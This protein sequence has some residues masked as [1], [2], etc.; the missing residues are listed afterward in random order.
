M[1]IGSFSLTWKPHM[2]CDGTCGWPRETELTNLLKAFMERIGAS[3]LG[4][5]RHEAQ[6]PLDDH[7]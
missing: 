6:E 1:T 3:L 7:V 4:C 5:L 2:E